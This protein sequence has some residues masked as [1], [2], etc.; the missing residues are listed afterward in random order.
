QEGGIEVEGLD[1]DV[2]EDG[3]RA[4][5]DDGVRRRGKAE[6]RDDDLV[7]GLHTQ[8]DESQVQAG[9][10][11]ADGGCMTRF[12]VLADRRFERRGLRSL[13]QV[14]RFDDL[15]DGFDLRVAGEGDVESHERTDRYQSMVSLSAASVSRGG[16]CPSSDSSCE[17]SARWRRTSPGR[18]SLWNTGWSGRSM[19]CRTRATRS[20]T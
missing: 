4:L 20:L 1:V 10:R 12:G 15:P 5:L 11:R 19:R 14:P 18:P 3:D 6:P 7:A 17:T 13:R 16:L 9:R 2:D 8:R